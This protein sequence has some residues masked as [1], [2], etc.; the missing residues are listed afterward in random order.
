MAA[1][2]LNLGLNTLAEAMHPSRP[3]IAE[4]T[5]KYDSLFAPASYAFSI[6]G[7][8]NLGFISYACYALRE[9]QRNN[10]IH[11]RLAKG[12]VAYALLGMAWVDVFRRDAIGLSLVIAAAMAGVGAAM[13]VAAHRAVTNGRLGRLGRI[14]FSIYF[15]WTSVAL[16]ANTSLWLK[17]WG[18]RGGQ[19]GEPVCTVVMLALTVALGIGVSRVYRDRTYSLVI[20]WAT[21][22]I[23][24]EQRG[25]SFMVSNT[26]LLAAVVMMGW[27]ASRF[28]RLRRHARVPGLRRA[29]AA[30]H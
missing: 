12:L 27:L 26:A 11:D 19:F 22:A 1:L 16:I 17:S 7:L 21:I 30:G 10:P 25:D 24:I 18:W 6:W 2:A 8:I 4:I 15:G 29:S 3:S 9:K 13:F 23:W 28:V 20:L 14:P 5:D